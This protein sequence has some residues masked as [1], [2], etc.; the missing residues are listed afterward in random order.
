MNLSSQSIIFVGDTH[1]Y[2]NDFA[3]QQEIIEQHKPD[4]VLSEQ[5][6]DQVLDSPKAYARFHKH[7]LFSAFIRWQEF[8]NL[9]AYCEKKNI[10]LIGI[11]LHDFGF[12]ASLHDVIAGITPPTLEQE[13]CLADILTKR[14]THQVS[15]INKYVSIT[16]KPLVVL[17][18]TWHLQEGMPLRQSFP[19]S[20]IIY[21]CDEKGTMLIEPPKKPLPVRYCTLPT[22]APNV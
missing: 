11:D 15:V 17:V 12:D 18:G 20:L 7:S 21:P 10:S 5:L 22:S 6:Q 8:N 3:K 14:Q 13:R 19:D 1:G 2:W 9:V 16:K 4:V